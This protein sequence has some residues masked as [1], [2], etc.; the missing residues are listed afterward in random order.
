MF[1]HVEAFFRTYR[2]TGRTMNLQ[3]QSPVNI[4]RGS[5]S[6]NPQKLNAGGTNTTLLDEIEEAEEEMELKRGK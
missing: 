2:L 5:P 3:P 4:I 1:P 6:S